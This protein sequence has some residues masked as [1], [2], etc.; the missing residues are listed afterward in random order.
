MDALSYVGGIFE[1]IIGIFSFVLIFSKI[2][3]EMRFAKKFFRT[4]LAKNFNFKNIL[5]QFGYK[6]LQK[7]KCEP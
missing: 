3:Y 2:L 6:G 5:Q 7:I 4:K 1:S